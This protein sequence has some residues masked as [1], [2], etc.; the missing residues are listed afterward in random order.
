MKNI[1]SEQKKIIPLY[2]ESMEVIKKHSG[3]LQKLLQQDKEYIP[4]QL[5][6]TLERGKDGM[7]SYKQLLESI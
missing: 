3:L 2:M 7:N 5:M 4:L 1:R 6:Q